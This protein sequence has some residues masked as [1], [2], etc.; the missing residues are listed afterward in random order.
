MTAATGGS[1]RPA[2]TP[3]PNDEPV[4]STRIRVEFGDCDPAEIVYFPNY[5]RWFD[6]ATHGLCEA[7]GYALMDVRARRS[8]VGYP[9]AEAGARFLA[10]ATVGDPLRI[11]TRVKVWRERFFELEHRV[12]RD[13]LLL[14]EGWQTRFIGFH[15]AT[16]GGKLAALV[17]PA[18]F[19][20][21]VER[22]AGGR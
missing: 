11:D 10:P 6:Q 12:F 4:H 18:E 19:R 3:W 15:D 5:Y 17:I 2:V 1:G 8:W 16:R 14:V 7:A 21:A 22:Q 13:D 20:A 9:I